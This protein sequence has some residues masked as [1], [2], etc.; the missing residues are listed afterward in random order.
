MKDTPFGNF[1]NQEYIVEKNGNIL[2]EHKMLRLL[3]LYRYGGAFLEDNTIVLKPF[4]FLART[5]LNMISLDKKLNVDPWIIFFEKDHKF[6]H[7]VLENFFTRTKH[8][9]ANLMSKVRVCF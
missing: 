9:E 6:L 3:L 8:K 5:G 2:K 1:S 7:D 4:G